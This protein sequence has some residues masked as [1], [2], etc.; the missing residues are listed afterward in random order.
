MTSTFH[1]EPEFC[2]VA[3]AE[4]RIVGFALGITI[5]KPRFAWTYGHLAWLGVDPSHHRFKIATKLFTH[6][7][8][9]M[10]AH[11]VRILLIETDAENE[12]G[13]RFFKKTGFSHPR[14]HVYTTMNLKTD[15]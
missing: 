13:I 6:F 14:N 8:E 15:T 10:E 3:D 4:D 9:T 1:E 12:P 7:R 5:K 2:L 11:G